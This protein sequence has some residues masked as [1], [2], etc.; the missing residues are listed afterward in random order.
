VWFWHN[1]GET[2]IALADYRR[3]IDAL[4]TAL[5]LDPQHEPSLQKLKLAR[6]ND[7]ENQ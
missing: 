4:E 2:L 6:E 5:L 3:A 7:E 1:Y